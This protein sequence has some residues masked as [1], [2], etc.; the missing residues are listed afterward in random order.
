L[1]P[2]HHK[3]VIAKAI[4]SLSPRKD[5]PFIKMNCGAIPETIIDSELFGHEKGVFTGAIAQK[6]GHF[7]RAQE[8]MILLDEIGE[9]PHDAQLRMVRVLQEKEIYRVGGSKPIKVNIRLIAATHRNLEDLVQKGNFR[10]DLYFRQRVFPSSSIA[11]PD[12]SKKNRF[13]VSLDLKTGEKE[14]WGE[15]HSSTKKSQHTQ[16]QSA[17]RKVMS[18]G[19]PQ[20]GKRKHAHEIQVELTGPIHC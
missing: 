13:H 18:P 20:S 8:G 19:N 9:F 12:F 1:Q 16:N 6:R 3:E 2:K 5:R 15:Y 14:I 7:E 11:C 4:H 10:K 17:G